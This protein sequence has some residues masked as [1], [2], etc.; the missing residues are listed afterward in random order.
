MPWHLNKAVPVGIIM[1]ILSQAAVTLIYAGKLDQ[2]IQDHE[3]RLTTVEH[4]DGNIE[5]DLREMCERTAR[6]EARTE[7]IAK[8]VDRIANMLQAE[9]RR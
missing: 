1:A 4:F 9:K 2:T 5:K 6:V 3:R 8:S 7:D